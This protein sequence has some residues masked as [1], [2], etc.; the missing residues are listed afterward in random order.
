MKVAYFLRQVFNWNQFIFW[1][2][3]PTVIISWIAYELA[4]EK[5][6]DTNEV[7]IVLSAFSPILGLICYFA[8][9][10]EDKDAANVYLGCAA[11]SFAVGFLIFV[12]L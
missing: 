2:I 10:N 5:E 3:L 6:Y 12:L 7:L 8:R 1:M 9:K 4:K 11:A